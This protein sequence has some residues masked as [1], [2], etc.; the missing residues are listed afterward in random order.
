MDQQPSIR[1][2]KRSRVRSTDCGEYRANLV[3]GEPNDATACL[4]VVAAC[5]ASER[6]ERATRMSRQLSLTSTSP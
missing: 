5:A 4:V 1:S 6:S 2:T 3:A